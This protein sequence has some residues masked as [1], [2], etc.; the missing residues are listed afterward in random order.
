MNYTYTKVE[1]TNWILYILNMTGW[2]AGYGT[3]YE[4]VHITMPKAFSETGSYA[5]MAACPHITMVDKKGWTY[6][7]YESSGRKY[8]EKNRLV[9][10]GSTS[11][12]SAV[13]PA[14]SSENNLVK[15]IA[16]DIG[17]MTR[18]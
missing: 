13:Y 4:E 5:D 18:P 16:A 2:E 17:T 1:K 14:T 7:R 3:V 12:S 10:K 8:Q 6:H 15:L 9:K 11:Y